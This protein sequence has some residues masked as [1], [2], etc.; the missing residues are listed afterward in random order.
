MLSFTVG[1][2]FLNFRLIFV[3][4]QGINLL[5][6]PIHYMSCLTIINI[7]LLVCSRNDKNVNIRLILP[8]TKFTKYIYGKSFYISPLSIFSGMKLFFYGGLLYH[9]MVKINVVKI[10]AG[11]ALDMT[12]ISTMVTSC[13]TQ[14][15]QNIYMAKAS[16]YHL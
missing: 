14:N 2:V 7:C 5:A 3:K 1:Y 8:E 10:I 6:F 13:L 12:R 4:Y 16:T 11:Y 15:L 9:Q